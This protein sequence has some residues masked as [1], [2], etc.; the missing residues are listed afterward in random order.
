MNLH[1]YI[2]KEAVESQ[3]KNEH[4]V[5]R[6]MHLHDANFFQYTYLRASPVVIATHLDQSNYPSNQ[7]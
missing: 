3:A 5:R 2:N 6:V 1:T 4:P 7:Q